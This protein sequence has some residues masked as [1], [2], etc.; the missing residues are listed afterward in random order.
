[1]RKAVVNLLSN[2]LKFTPKGGRIRLTATRDTTSALIIRV[3][4]NGIG[5][6]PDKIKVALEPFGQ[7]DTGLARKYE[8]AGLGLPLA[9]RLIELHGGTLDI[10]SAPGEGTSITIRIPSRR[11]AVGAGEPLASLRA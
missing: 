5:I 11:L 7:I 3:E 1:L 4:D 6:A 2:A 9:K 10:A 8:G